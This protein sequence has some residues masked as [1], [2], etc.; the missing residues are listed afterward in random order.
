[1]LKKIT[2]LFLSALLLAV[3]AVP[4]CASGEGFFG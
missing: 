1:M 3:F 4:A 2:A